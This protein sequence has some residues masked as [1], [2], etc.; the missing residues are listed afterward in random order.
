[1]V[2]CHKSWKC[3]KFK[4]IH[5]WGERLLTKEKSN[6]SKTLPI[7]WSYV[8]V[9]YQDVRRIVC[10]YFSLGS[11]NIKLLSLWASQYWLIVIRTFKIICRKPG[12]FRRKCRKNL[13]EIES[14]VEEE[15][16]EIGQ[17][18]GTS[19]VLSTNFS[20]VLWF[21]KRHWEE[22][23]SARRTVYAVSSGVAEV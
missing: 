15:M 10:Y 21:P 3:T 16:V 4:V 20:A 14:F 6:N 18:Q 2:L 13:G 5:F 1:M 19:L 17:L 23:I 8:Y 7:L 9:P 22:W 12:F 11:T